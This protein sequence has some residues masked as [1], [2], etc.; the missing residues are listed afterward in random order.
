[1]RTTSIASISYR[2]YDP[3]SREPNSG[4]I[5]KQKHHQGGLPTFSHGVWLPN[6]R[7][8]D[9]GWSLTLQLTDVLSKEKR[10]ARK[11]SRGASQR[12]RKRRRGKAP[13]APPPAASSGAV[14]ALF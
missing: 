14:L 11:N 1:M 5:V 2:G 12:Q 6:A 4:K 9:S 7:A 8:T 13:A 10:P 3:P